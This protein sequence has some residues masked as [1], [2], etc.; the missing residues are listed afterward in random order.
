M[1]LHWGNSDLTLGKGSLREDSQSLEGLP[2]APSLSVFKEYLKDA[3]D[4]VVYFQ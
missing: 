2:T 1:K 3:L 4:P